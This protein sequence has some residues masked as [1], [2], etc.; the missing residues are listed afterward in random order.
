VPKSI[1]VLG[2]K[3]ETPVDSDADHV[4]VCKV[5]INSPV[6]KASETLVKEV[7]AE[8]PTRIIEASKPCES[9]LSN[10]V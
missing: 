4:D 8:A 2:A 1:G 5:G 6:Y 3:T 9:R 10:S 7:M